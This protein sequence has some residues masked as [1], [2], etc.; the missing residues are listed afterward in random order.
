M[1]LTMILINRLL[2]KFFEVN[3]DVKSKKTGLEAYRN[4]YLHFVDHEAAVTVYTDR[5]TDT[6]THTHNHTIVYL[7]CACALIVDL[8][9]CG[10]C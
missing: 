2:N 9:D 3:R 5:Q 10:E 4:S 6:H 7:A 8:V 1:Q